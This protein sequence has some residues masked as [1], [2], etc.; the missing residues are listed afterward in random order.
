[1]YELLDQAPYAATCCD[2][3]VPGLPLDYCN[4]AFA[5]L[6]GWPCAEVVGKNCR[7]LQNERTEPRALYE[8]ITAIRTCTA[9]E[10]QI[11]NVKKDG[12]PFVNAL[13]THPIFDTDGKCRFMIAILSDAAKV[14][15]EGPS[16][17]S[18]RAHLPDQPV[19]AALFPHA[20]PRFEPVDP[21]EQ[22]KESQKVNTKLIRLLWATE[23][24]GA[25]R[26][27][28]TMQSAMMQQFVVSMVGFLRQA[29]RAD[30]EALLGKLLMQQQQGTWD[31]I[32]G[33]KAI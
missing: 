30:D 9:I 15:I 21:L 5:A 7:F 24:D 19:D 22:W 18:L 12:T 25:L 27:L 8:L 33:R 11:T 17:Q 29:N 10:L 13:S 6:T 31:P 3:S 23:P 16:L 2:M 20:R 1:L 28:L 32:A 26:Q 4:E 14:A